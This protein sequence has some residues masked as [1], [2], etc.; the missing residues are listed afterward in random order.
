MALNNKTN[1]ATSNAIDELKYIIDPFQTHFS[2]PLQKL[3][4]RIEKPV[5]NQLVCPHF[6]RLLCRIL[7]VPT[8][9][10][11]TADGLRSFS[12]T[13]DSANALNPE[14]ACHSTGIAR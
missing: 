7:Q 14:R 11:L 12:K 4:I 6:L 8:Y 10:I 1:T 5:R 9:R 13:F 3:Q 2:D